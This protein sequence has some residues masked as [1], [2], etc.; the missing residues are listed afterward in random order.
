MKV[1]NVNDNQIRKVSPQRTCVGCRKG[2][3]REKLIRIVSSK[4]GQLVP[5]LKARLPGRGA[6]V[7]CA[8]SCIAK[9][10]RKNALSH[11]LKRSLDPSELRLLEQK[12]H[13]SLETRILSFLSVLMKGKKVVLG[14]ESIRKLLQ[15]NK[16]HLLL[17]ADDM[18]KSFSG[19][20]AANVP[21][22]VLFSRDRLGR[23]LGKT[24]QPLLGI[25]DA[26]GSKELMRMIDMKLALE[27]GR[28]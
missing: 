16:V 28:G 10:V 23:T 4:E 14:R 13:G 22:R 15:K 3:D 2:R 1:T 9:A 25:T 8:S 17:Q 6:Y 19:Y 26:G 11:S 7:C 12:I 18:K 27:E 20:T 5:D 21:V 24:A